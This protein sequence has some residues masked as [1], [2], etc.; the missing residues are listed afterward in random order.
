MNKLYYLSLVF[1]FS[2]KMFLVA[3]ELSEPV[4]DTINGADSLSIELRGD[5]LVESA[6]LDD[7]GRKKQKKIKI[8][9]YKF[10]FKE[11]LAGAFFMMAFVAVILSSV[12]N[13]NPD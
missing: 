8:Q 2:G 10:K 9:H 6:A 11:Q 4:T 3:D 1:I 7:S 13:W 12:Q 5:T